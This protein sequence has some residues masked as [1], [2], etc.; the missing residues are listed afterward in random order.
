MEQLKE[1]ELKYDII[2]TQYNLKKFFKLIYRDI[3]FKEESIR[4]FQNNNNNYKKESTYSKV[5]FFNDIDELIKFSTNKYIRQNNTY[6]N[7]ATT[8]GEGG[9]E[10]HLKYRYCLGFDF[11][12][13]DNP[14]LTAK[15]I[16]N[17]FKK[18]KIHYHALVDSGNGYHVYVC[19]NKTSNLKMVD[20][21]QKELIK[22]LGADKEADLKTQILRVPYTFNIKD[23]PKRVKIITMDDRNS[24]QF[25]PYN[26]EFLY[27]K[28]CIQVGTHEEGIQ[29][30]YILNNTNIPNCIKSVIENGSEEGN[31][32]KDLQNIVVAL[33]QRN[34]TLGEITQVCKEWALKSNY[35]DNLNYRVENIYYNK[36]GLELNCK[37]CLEFDSCYSK[38]ISNFEFKEDEQI[39]TLSETNMNKLKKSNRKGVK[40]MKSNDL[41]VYCILKNHN[42][43]LTR[44]ELLNELTYTKKKVVKNVALSERTL[45]DTL[46]SLEEN[47]FIEV[48]RGV[49]K[50][51]IKDIY[52]LKEE[53]SKV[54]LTYNISFS[55]A[56]ECIKGNISTE[57]LRLYNYMR[58]LHHKKQREDVKALKGNLFQVNQIDLA[59]ELGVTQGRI[60]AM[61]NNLLDEKILSI[62]YRQPSKNNG[63]DFNIYRLNY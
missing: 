7:L 30:K 61:I 32:Y 10:E 47:G 35:D 56:Y 24:D 4:V 9:A 16:L 44:E 57:E 55:V 38:V 15:D 6:F 52:K 18:L 42:D 28:N 11:D 8:D 33:R 45:K 63:F 25:R 36:H 22:R 46:K 12:K 21:V 39:I 54:E 3:D 43:G 40:I 13:K 2:D 48:I 53:R 60:S 41:L 34:K 1:Q 31:R 58:Y 50:L 23:Y 29:S 59:K 51:G 49:K 26:I 37:E 62:W 27:K 17:K 14:G 5:L 19:I 20:E